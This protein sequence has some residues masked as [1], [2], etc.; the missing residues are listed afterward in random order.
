MDFILKIP[1]YVEDI[2]LSSWTETFLQILLRAFFFVLD[3]LQDFSLT[4]LTGSVS[5]INAKDI[6]TC[7]CIYRQNDADNPL[8]VNVSKT[9]LQIFIYKYRIQ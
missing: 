9:H 5:E 8:F 7:T 3:I 4:V 2:I 1:G 6:G